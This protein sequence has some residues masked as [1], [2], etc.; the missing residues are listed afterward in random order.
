MFKRFFALIT[1]L[2]L[3]LSVLLSGCSLNLKNAFRKEKETP[4]SDLAAD[5]LIFDAQTSYEK[6]KQLLASAQKSIYIEQTIFSEPELMNLVIQKAKSGLDVRILLDQFITPNRTTLNELK[7]QNI[8]VQYYPARKGQTLDTKF[9]VTDFSKAL[10]YSSPWTS[11]GFKSYNL[12]VFLTEKSAWKLAGIFNRDWQF[13]TTL[14]LDVPK[15]TDLPEDNILLATNAKVK[16]Q[17]IEHISESQK[18]IWATVTEVT[19][20][21]MVQ[22]FV[23]AAKKGRDVRLIL[24]PKI[25]PENWPETLNRLKSAGIQIRYFKHPEN[26]PLS[27]YL[28]IFD[29]KNFIMSSSGWS[30]TS[31]IMDHELSLTVPSPEAT[32]ALIQRFDQDWQNSTETP[33]S[34]R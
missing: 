30:Y 20:E 6:T 29:G 22:A 15:E 10:V 14:S 34:A 27:L 5:A 32:Y 8:S 23:D 28:G 3:L 25:M 18:S 1:I 12:T 33:I 17:I 11:E 7:Q 13:T 2:S 19:E 4:V 31:F 24:S 26:K 16:Q 9:L 21:D